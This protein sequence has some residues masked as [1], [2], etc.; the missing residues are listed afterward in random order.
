MI[1][2]LNDLDRDYPYVDNVKPFS[3][4]LQ[5]FGASALSPGLVPFAQRSQ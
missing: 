2:F 4:F 1:L 5:L 3:R